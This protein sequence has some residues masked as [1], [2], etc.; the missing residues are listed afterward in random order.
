MNRRSYFDPIECRWIEDWEPTQ[1]PEKA[2]AQTLRCYSPA[3]FLL[4]LE[5]TGLC[6]KRL[7]L[8]GSALE[9]G[10]GAI[11]RSGP[12]MTAYDYQVQLVLASTPNVE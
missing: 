12:L 6:L 5:G 9:F 8:D 4:L 2:L 1:A 3:D 7:E 11:T 10:T